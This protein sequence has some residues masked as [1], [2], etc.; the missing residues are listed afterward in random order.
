MT[1]VKNKNNEK[2][3]IKILV[4][5]ALRDILSDPDFGLKLK[6]EIVRKLKKKPKKL[7]PLEEVKKIVYGK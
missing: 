2:L 5:E 6:P 4:I 7:I 3:R 1:S